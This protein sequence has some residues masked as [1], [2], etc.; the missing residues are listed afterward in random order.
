MENEDLENRVLSLEQELNHIRNY[1]QRTLSYQHSDPEAALWMARKAT[2]AICRQIFV[3]E[4]SPNIGNA[5]LEELLVQL[6]K[7]KAIPKGIEVPIRTIQQY[8]NFGTHDQGHDNI[9]ITQEFAEPCLKSLSTVVDWYFNEY[10]GQPLPVDSFRLQPGENM[11]QPAILYWWKSPH[12]C[13]LTIIIPGL[14]HLIIGQW[15]KAIAIFLFATFIAIASQSNPFFG[16]GF[17]I[18]AVATVDAYMSAK[19]ILNGRTLGKFQWFPRAG[20]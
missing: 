12:I 20:K 16:P 14:A 10:L 18:Y 8:G 9:A 19:A 7:R 6:N 13:W 17:I 4:I 15:V 3:K 11:A 1:Y 2:E 5:T